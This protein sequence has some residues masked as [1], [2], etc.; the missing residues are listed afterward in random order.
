[1]LNMMSKFPHFATRLLW[2]HQK[3]SI[4][5]ERVNTMLWVLKVFRGQIRILPF[6]TY[7]KSAADNFRKFETTIWS[8]VMRSIL[9]L[10]T[11]DPKYSHLVWSGQNVPL[12]LNYYW[13]A[14][15][16]IDA[17]SQRYFG[18]IMAASSP[19]LCSLAFLHL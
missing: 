7:N 3:V 12:S 15:L 14:S 9:Y 13:F 8:S 18:Y 19:L 10:L 5:W 6:P 4:S 11:K 16:K 17:V 1:M 2:R